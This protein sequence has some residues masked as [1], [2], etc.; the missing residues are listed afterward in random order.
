MACITI[1]VD[2]SLHQRLAR[3]PWINWSEIGREALMK[4]YLFEKFLQTGNLTK[5]EEK[6]CHSIDWHPV[7]ELPLQQDYIKKIQQIRKNKHAK[8]MTKEEAQKW[9]D[10]L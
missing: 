6:F 1:S 4:R 5:E 8:P 2:Q 10:T 7:D 9:F 3:F